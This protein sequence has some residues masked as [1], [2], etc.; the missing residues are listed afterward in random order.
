MAC[1]QKIAL[2]FFDQPTSAPDTTCLSQTKFSFSVPV[3]SMDVKLGP[4]DGGLMGFSGLVPA[5]GCKPPT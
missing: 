4:F 1:P 5:N 3:A 2:A